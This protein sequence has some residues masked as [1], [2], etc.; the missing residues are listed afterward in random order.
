MS[1]VLHGSLYINSAG[2]RFTGASY[3]ALPPVF[4]YFHTTLQGDTHFCRQLMMLFNILT[5]WDRKL[6]PVNTNPPLK[7][8]SRVEARDQT[9][10]R[11][12]RMGQPDGKKTDIPGSSPTLLKFSY[13]YVVVFTI[14][15]QVTSFVVA[16][17]LY[18]LY[19][20]RIR[21]HCAVSLTHMH[22]E[23]KKC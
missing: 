9:Q 3:S 14:S 17:L 15:A 5:V 8:R 4:L 1:G 16:Y 2:V 13:N 20:R 21:T 7:A 10:I 19:G 18:F 11:S 22:I 23:K 12:S 6:P